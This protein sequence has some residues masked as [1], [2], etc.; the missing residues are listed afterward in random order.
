MAKAKKDDQEKVKKGAASTKLSQEMKADIE[1]MLE[2]IQKQT[3]KRFRVIENQ[4]EKLTG[5]ASKT[6]AKKADTKVKPVKAKEKG[7]LKK[8]ARRQVQ[9]A[10]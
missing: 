1:K 2:K 9:E 8:T 4:L 3:D 7:T 10:E 6:Q 5:G